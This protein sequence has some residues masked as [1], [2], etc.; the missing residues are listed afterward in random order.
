MTLQ[1]ISYRGRVVAA[2][3]RDRF[4]LTE[5]LDD[6]PIDDPERTFVIFMAVYAG[7]V[8]SGRLPGPYTDKDARRYA[9]AALIPAELLERD[10]RTLGHASHAL[11]VP[12]DELYA[13]RAEHL[14]RTRVP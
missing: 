3:T 7:D 9:R 14:A 2:A 12:V 6:R 8:L 13:A 11:R 10:P 1:P 5:E 4:F